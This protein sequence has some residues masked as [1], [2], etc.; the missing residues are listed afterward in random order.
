MTIYSV[1]R[2]LLG[3]FLCKGLLMRALLFGFQVFLWL[4]L[5]S[6]PARGTPGSLCSTPGLWC[7]YFSVHVL[8]WRMILYRTCM[9]RVLCVCVVVYAVCRAT[10]CDCWYCD[11]VLSVGVCCGWF[12]LSGSGM[13]LC[14]KLQV[15][16]RVIR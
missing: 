3:R 16:I 2:S 15:C 11:S 9:F 5:L 13:G 12:G 1:V 6:P 14:S 4:Q 8:M 10:E 7:R